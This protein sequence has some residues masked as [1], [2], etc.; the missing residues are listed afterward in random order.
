MVHL[1]KAE[2]NRRRST[3]PAPVDFS[4]DYQ[5]FSGRWL[6]GFR[7]K[8]LFLEQST[9]LACVDLRQHFQYHVFRD[10]VLLGLRHGK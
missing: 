5:E 4:M 10:P 7:R 1:P 9:L 8:R 3:C 2:P 6:D